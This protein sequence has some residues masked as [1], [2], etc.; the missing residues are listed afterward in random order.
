MITENPRIREK[1]G[2]SEVPDKVEVEM[3]PVKLRQL[4]LLNAA[5]R[6][7]KIPG[8]HPVVLGIF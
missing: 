1:S 5:P 3:G 4:L 2:L 7:W 6:H 8:R